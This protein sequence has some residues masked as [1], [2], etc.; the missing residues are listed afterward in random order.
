MVMRAKNTLK[1]TEALLS[2][3]RERT[4]DSSEKLNKGDRELC[5]WILRTAKEDL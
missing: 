2:P 4:V 5:L 3:Y 1:K